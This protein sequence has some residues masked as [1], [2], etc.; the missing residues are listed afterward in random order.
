MLCIVLSDRLMQIAHCDRVTFADGSLENKLDF[1][2]DFK[3]DLY[4]V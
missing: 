3:Y 4:N 2:K 1:L